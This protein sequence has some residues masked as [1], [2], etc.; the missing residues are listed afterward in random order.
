MIDQQETK[1]GEVPASISRWLYAIQ[2]DEC[3]TCGRRIVRRERVGRCMYAT[4][5]GHLLYQG[6]VT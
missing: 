1:Q 3:P 6:K 4:P 2:H 5:C